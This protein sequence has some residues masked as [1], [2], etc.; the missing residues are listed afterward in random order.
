MSRLRRECGSPAFLKLRIQA[1]CRWET[2]PPSATLPHGPAGKSAPP[3]LSRGPGQTSAETGRASVS[4]RRT[5]PVAVTPSSWGS[6]SGRSTTS[7]LL[8]GA[9]RGWGQTG[10]QGRTFFRLSSSLPCSGGRRFGLYCV[11]LAAMPPASP[12]GPAAAVAAGCD[13]GPRPGALEKPFQIPAHGP[14]RGGT[15]SVLASL[16]ATTLLTGCDSHFG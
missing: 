16:S 13:A 7:F 3:R 14:A 11:E 8:V 5:G 1:R 6:T 15:D 12:A 10:P 4:A 9:A 2:R